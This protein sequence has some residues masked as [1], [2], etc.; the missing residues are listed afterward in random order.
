MDTALANR[1]RAASQHATILQ[2]Y[3]S[4]VLRKTAMRSVGEVLFER[5][6]SSASGAGSDWGRDSSAYT[7][8]AL[9]AGGAAHLAPFFN[10][11]NKSQLP[12]PAGRTRATC[13]ATPPAVNKGGRSVW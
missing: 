13:Y 4:T 12:Q 10:S 8:R 3:H 1:Y 2:Q 11:L 7:C 5:A 9:T 6:L